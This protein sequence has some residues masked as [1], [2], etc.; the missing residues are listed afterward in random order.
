M[1]NVNTDNEY[2]SM[3]QLKSQDGLL[4]RNSKAQSFF[5][6]FRFVLQN[7]IANLCEQGMFQERC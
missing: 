4:E 2:I 1:N 3:D 7:S 6:R 5:C